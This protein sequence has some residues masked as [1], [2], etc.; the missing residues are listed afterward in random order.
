[1]ATAT[2]RDLRTSFPKVRRALET[3][4]E[5]IVTEHGRP[6]YLLRPY[7]AASSKPAPAIDY[8]ERLRRRMPR[9]MS[10]ARR[11]AL[12]EENRGPR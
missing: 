11:R 4:G 12:D 2:I 8:Y 1:M 7:D 5:V 6:A 9:P 10:A 3:D